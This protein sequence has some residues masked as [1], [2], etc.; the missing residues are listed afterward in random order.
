MDLKL[1]SVGQ[2]QAGTHTQGREAALVVRTLQPMLPTAP[3]SLN[4]QLAQLL[5]RPEKLRRG[6]DENTAEETGLPRGQDTALRL[7]QRLQ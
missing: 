5:Q 2:D 1:W 4:A 6:P 3:C 7:Q